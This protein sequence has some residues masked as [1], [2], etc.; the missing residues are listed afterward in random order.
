MVKVKVAKVEDYSTSAKVT[1][2]EL[3]AT[4]AYYYPQYTFK[5]AGELKARDLYQLLNTARKLESVRYLNLV[6]I[7]A[8]PHSKKGKAVKDLIKHYEEIIKGK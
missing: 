6:Q 4:I 1:K 5:E 3:Y 8:S 2:R 7:V